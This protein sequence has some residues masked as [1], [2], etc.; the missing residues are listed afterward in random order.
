MRDLIIVIGGGLLR[1]VFGAGVVTSFQKANLYSR[2][3]SVYGISAGAHDG[4]Y[5]I[6]NQIDVVSSVYFDELVEHKFVRVQKLSY[7]LK[8]LFKKRKYNL[9]NIP[10]LKRIEYTT[11]KLNFNKLKKSKINFNVLV[12]NLNKQRHEFINGKI[13]PVERINTSGGAQPF[14]TQPTQ[15]NKYDYIDG[16]IFTNHNYVNDLIKKHPNKKIII[17]M[18]IQENLLYKIKQLPYELF[19][20]LLILKLYGFKVFKKSI[21]SLFSTFPYKEISKNNNVYLIENKFNVNLNS[22]NHN[23]LFKLYNQGINDGNDFL[24][25]ILKI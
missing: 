13:D 19:K 7:Y 1:G 22:T 14:Y 4:A 9:V 16:E 12:F 23:E 8:S 2:V 6:T 11:K 18:N 3:H 21:G 24:K 20:S 17:I 5:F 25:N 10:Y 15:I